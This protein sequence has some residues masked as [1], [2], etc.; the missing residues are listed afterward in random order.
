MNALRLSWHS[1]CQPNHCPKN[2]DN[3]CRQIMTLAELDK[4]NALL[5]ELHALK[6]QVAA[7]VTEPKYGCRK[8]N[9]T[10]TRV[11]IYRSITCDGNNES[12][13]RGSRY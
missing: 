12:R 6:L 9:V 4:D 11:K 5:L 10:L 7:K 1:K 13:S 3:K 8:I 2:N